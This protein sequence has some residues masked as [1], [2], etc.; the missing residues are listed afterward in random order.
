MNEG[1][2]NGMNLRNIIIIGAILSIVAGFVIGQFVNAEAPA[3]GSSDDP[4][5]SKSYVDKAVEERLKKLE[6]DVAELTVQSQALQNTINELQN[7]INKKSGSSSSSSGT[8]SQN[9]SSSTQQQEANVGKTAYVRSSN[10]YVNL[11]KGPTTADDVV[12]KVYKNDPMTI[13]KAQN[14]WYQVK[15]KDGTTTGWV[16]SWVVDVK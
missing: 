12:K 7:K 8:S 2:E 1:V 6:A 3:P 13:Q 4:V 10:N 14:Q 15:L 11:R 9:N 5:V 16:A